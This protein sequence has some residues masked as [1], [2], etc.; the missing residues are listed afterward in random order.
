M[1]VQHACVVVADAARARLYTF[2]RG[3]GVPQEFCERVDLVN[4]ERRQRPSEVH[5]DTRPGTSYAPTGI[6]FAVDDHRDAH[7]TEVDRRFAGEINRELSK[8]LS[9]T[10]YRH[11][12]VVASHRMLGHLRA[13]YAQPPTVALH[14]LTL[15]LT[16][17]PT[18]ALHDR[19]SDLGLLPP[20]RRVPAS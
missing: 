11:A 6:G 4:P 7:Q 19:L 10:G 8:L 5:S 15:D 1:P 20:R 12:I 16:R 17:E 3:E 18:A 2:Q 9:E 13:A 14:E